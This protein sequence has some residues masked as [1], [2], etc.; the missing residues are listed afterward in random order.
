MPSTVGRPAI[1]VGVDSSEN[2]FLALDWAVE[3]AV[4]RDCPIRMIHAHKPS[5][6]RHHLGPQAAM[7]EMYA[8][9]QAVFAAARDHLA[10]RREAN[11]VVGTALYAGPP[12]AVLAEL[13]TGASLCVVGRKGRVRLTSFVLGSTAVHLVARST[14]PLVVV[15]PE[16]SPRRDD[17][18]HGAPPVVVG[19]DLPLRRPDVLEFAFRAAELTGVPLLALCAWDLGIASE[20]GGAT[21]GCAEVERI[22]ADLLATWRELHPQVQ[23]E[24]AAENSRPAE[25]LVKYSA[26]ASLLVVGAGPP[27]PRHGLAATRLVGPKAVP[28]AGRVA[29]PV[30]RES[31]CPV[32]VV[33]APPVTTPGG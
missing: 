4:R 30:L 6:A 8:E 27:A 29:S 14:V 28:P 23:V 18:G 19:V 13:A 22:V 24:A 9:G 15:P 1:V 3:E 31:S 25:A 2:A 11:R 32:A 20:T 26:R 17:D 5:A 12:A 16:W 21:R 10:G 33:P 7:A